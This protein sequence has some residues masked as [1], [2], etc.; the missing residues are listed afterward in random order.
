MV[1]DLLNIF[2]GHIVFSVGI[3][4]FSG[5][6][7]GKIAERLKLPAITGYIF[8][9]LL[10]GK[11]SL[12]IIPEEIA[13]SMTSVTELALGMIALIIGGEFQLTKLKESGIKIIFLTICQAALT[14]IFTTIAMAMI[15]FDIQIALLLGAIATATAPAATVVIIKQ[16]KAK[17]KFVD[18]LYGIVAFDDA[19]CVIIFSIIFAI[20]LPSLTN[21]SSGE[22]GIM[23]GLIHA[24]KHIFLSAIIGTIS[25]GLLHY[26]CKKVYKLNEIMIISIAIIFMN[27]S[28]SLILDLS[29][30]IANMVLGAVL[31]N[32]STKNSRI[33]EVL[34]PF[35]IPI[36]ALFFIIA[37]TELDVSVFA[38]GTVIIY[39]GVYIISRF[40]GKYS[41]IYFGSF[42][43]KCSVKVRNYLGFC[44]I[45]QAGVAIGLVLLVQTNPEIIAAPAE[46]KQTLIILVNVVLFSIFIN[47]LI[48]P[49]I[50]KFGI[51]R[52]IEK[53]ES[54]SR[55]EIGN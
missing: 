30:L 21:Q 35:T 27:T 43:I 13:M 38:Q 9:G 29:L 24:L 14:L 7:L 12:N 2:T 55:L 19:L 44:L 45:P 28:I 32:L 25:A 53:N 15:G 23:H 36:F 37:G 22:S 8:T 34:D 20:V 1:K 31:I 33:L 26:L 3:L 18:Y 51:I 42:F 47:E 11:Y 5:Y 4:L 6:F 41:G 16:L 48:G 17:G 49:A 39:G 40:I 10:L 46:V 54:R 50:S 52:G